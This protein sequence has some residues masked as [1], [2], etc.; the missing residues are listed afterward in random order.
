MNVVPFKREHLREMLVQESQLHHL[1]YLTD[2]ILTEM[3]RSFSF[4][5]MRD[6][7]VYMCGGVFAL[8]EWRGHSWSYI[9]EKAGKYFI[10][11]ARITN[12]CLEMSGFKRIEADVDEDFVQGHRFVKLLGFK[13]E[14]LSRVGFHSDGRS[15][16]LYAR[17]T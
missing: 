14:A 3:E 2:Q 16:S 15:C 6:N 7:E 8:S 9:S 1:Q 10:Q 5:A 17:I 4:T 11:L 13:L 12:R